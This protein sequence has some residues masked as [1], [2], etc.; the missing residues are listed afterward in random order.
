MLEPIRL[1][2]RASLHAGYGKYVPIADV[3]AESVCGFCDDVVPQKS[4]MFLD[5]RA[6]AE[7][8]AGAA[9][10]PNIVQSR[11]LIEPGAALCS[12]RIARMERNWTNGRQGD[13]REAVS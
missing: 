12:V 6:E 3:P 13:C 2:A 5:A 9:L 10:R 1:P 8:T 4:R 7:I 11:T